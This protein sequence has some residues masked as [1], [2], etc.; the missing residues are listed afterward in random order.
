MIPIIPTVEIKGDSNTKIMARSGN[1]VGLSKTRIV[2]RFGFLPESDLAKAFGVS[3]DEFHWVLA[4]INGKVLAEH[5]GYGT[6]LP[7]RFKLVINSK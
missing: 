1:I 5:H 4:E 3:T 7:D 2:W 6:T